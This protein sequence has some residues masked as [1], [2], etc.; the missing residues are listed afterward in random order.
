MKTIFTGKYCIRLEKIHSTNSYLADL[1]N[2]KN[3]T[4][5]TAVITNAQE[6]GRGQRGTYWESEA[7]KNLTLSIFLKPTFLKPDEQF[8]LSKAI[9]LG[10]LDFVA[11]INNQQSTI[12][13]PKVK[14]PNDI[15]IGTKKIA[16]ILIENSVNGNSISH[17]IVGIGINVN[18]E[19][20]SVELPNPTSLKLETGKE[21]DLEESLEQLCSCI[22]KRY[23]QL[24][25]RPKEIDADYM[26]N[27]YRFNEW[28]SYVYQGKKLKAKIAGVTKI[29]KL[30]L[31]KEVE[32][33]LECDFKEVEFIFPSSSLQED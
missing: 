6:Q 18:Q 1:C 21:F 9:S 16:G 19:N 12:H 24:R 30:V 10:V 22:E 13:Y 20:F 33:N 5:G 29:G 11:S 31:E 28:A 14:W 23:L 2:E 17:S 25:N 7:G 3:L 32:K 26:E 27:L 4:E 15:Y 8:S